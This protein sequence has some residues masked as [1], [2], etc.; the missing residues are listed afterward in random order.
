[1]RHLGRDVNLLKLCITKRQC[2]LYLHKE[3][4][5]ADIHCTR[6]TMDISLILGG[7]IWVKTNKKHLRGMRA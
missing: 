2:Y 1:L 3:T 7:N 4:S 5:A 6:Q